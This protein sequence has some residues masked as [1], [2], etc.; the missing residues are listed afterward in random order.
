MSHETVE[1]SSD[2][3]MQRIGRLQAAL[4]QDGLDGALILQKTDLYYFS[5]TIQQGQ[6]YVPARGEPVL[7]VRKS[8][9]RAR[10]ESP[11]PNQVSVKSPRQMPEV[12]TRNG[13]DLP[14]RLGLELDVIPA[15]LF[16]TLEEIF[17]DAWSVDVSDISDTVRKI[18]AVK[19]EA[20]IALI[21]EA[22]QGAD[23]VAE[24]AAGAIREGISEVA[25]AGQVE[26]EAR[27]LGH[28]G[29]VRMRMWDMEMF[30]GHLMAGAG[31]A[32]PSY[33]ASPTGGAALSPAVAQ[34]ASTRP[35]RRGEPILLDYVFAK[36]G[37]L[38]DHSRIFAIGGVEAE[39]AA[40]HKS[41]L[42]I[43]EALKQELRP[44]A[45][46]G[47]IY[48]LA[49]ELAKDR[50][51]ADHFMGADDERIRFVGHGI[52]LELDEYPVLAKGQQMPLEAGMVIALEPKMIFP[53]RGVVGIE[54]THLI[55]EDG[56][57]QLTRFE[58]DIVVV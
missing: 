4:R 35:I 26:A 19:S 44:G 36:N 27:R 38:A 49:I 56:A 42:A 3:I 13:I 22:A 23:R 47:R 21:R 39:L 1:I 29:F 28:Q 37:Y 9:R 31:A 54:N 14:R 15:R 2:E 58:E 5:G 33:L 43:Q 51:L 12:L 11:I 20:E 16:L 34:G 6:F 52:G 32:V 53:G 57:E 25:L 45:A 8:S 48:A 7:M 18:R 41:V 55:T 46:A 24:F 50:G 40:A 17:S 30:Y 10:A